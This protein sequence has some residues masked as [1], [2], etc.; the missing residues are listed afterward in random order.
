MLLFLLYLLIVNRL[1]L[2]M[3]CGQKIEKPK[4]KPFCPESMERFDKTAIGYESVWACNKCGTVILSLKAV[5]AHVKRC[6]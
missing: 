4:K 5:K 2:E 3:L 6:S 1:V